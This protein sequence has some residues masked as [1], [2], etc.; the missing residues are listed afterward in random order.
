VTLT[1]VDLH[2]E[3]SKRTPVEEDCTCNSTFMLD[4]IREVGTNIGNAFHWL[5]KAT[6]SIH[7]FMD[8]SGGHSTNAAKEE[9]VRI[10]EDEFNVIVLWQIANSLEMNM[11][12]LGAW[13]TIQCIVTH[14]YRGKQVQKDALCKT[15]YHAFNSLES[16]KPSRT[17]KQWERILDLIILSKGSN[18]FVELCRSLTASLADLPSFDYDKDVNMADGN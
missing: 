18:N 14:M 8:N 15:V 2:I 17:G 6:T 16:T 12:D 5:P 1:D 13:V 7:L 10:L 9:Y 11:L 4:I 3:V